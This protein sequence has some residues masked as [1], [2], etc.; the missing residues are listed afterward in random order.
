MSS[1]PVK[2][3]RIDSIEEHPNADRLELAH[4]AGWQVVVQ[5]GR[6][7]PGMLAV[8]VPLDSILPTKLEEHLFPPDAKIKLEKSRVRSIKIRKALSQGM[9]I[10]PEDVTALYPELAKAKEDDDVADIL[11]VTKYEP[12]LPHYQR[13]GGPRQKGT[14]KNHPL[15]SKYT[16]I[17]NWKHY[18]KLFVDDEDVY[19][20][21][22][23]HGNQHQIWCIP[24]QSTSLIWLRSEVFD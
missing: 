11:G 1:H 5:K 7:Q 22:K 14:R 13:F 18:P 9:L 10:W 24:T 23:V 20:T 16:D 8:F 3:V 4:V 12:P 19:I 15:F 2:V 17:E 6:Y 21:E